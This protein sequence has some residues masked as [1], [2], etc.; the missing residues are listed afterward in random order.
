MG[1]FY[2]NITIIGASQ[3]AIISSLENHNRTAY[4]TPTRDGVT[5]VFDLQSDEIGEPVELGDIA[6][7]LSA[8]LT[9]V[10]MAAAV[11]DDDVLLLGLYDRGVQIGEY[12]TTGG[13]D[14]TARSIAR[15]LGLPSGRTVLLATLLRSPRFPLFVFETWRHHL[16]LKVLGLPAW[17]AATGYKYVHQGEPPPGLRPEELIHT[18]VDQRNEP[19]N[20]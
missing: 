12:T 18:G 5:V 1:N 19:S 17:A 15:V 9:C 6:I 7:T 2:K 16:I 10:A 3:A 13:S 4:V 8:D 11:Y 14:L 20:T